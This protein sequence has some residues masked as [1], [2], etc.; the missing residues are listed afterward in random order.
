MSDNK[1]K[2]N[3]SIIM[4]MTNQKK[5]RGIEISSYWK[6]TFFFILF[7]RQKNG[8]GWGFKMKKSYI[9]WNIFLSRWIK[10]I[11]KHLTNNYRCL[12]NVPRRVCFTNEVLLWNNINFFVFSWKFSPRFFGDSG[13][14]YFVWHSDPKTVVLMSYFKEK[15]FMSYSFHHRSSVWVE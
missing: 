5:N 9:F 8:T 12:I 10:T 6:N 3:T 4:I 2:Y 14:L 11:N 13:T 7:M 1:S 15:S